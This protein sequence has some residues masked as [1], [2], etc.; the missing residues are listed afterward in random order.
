[1][2]DWY[3]PKEF[4]IPSNIPVI[5]RGTFSLREPDNN[6]YFYFDCIEW[7]PEDP[8]YEPKPKGEEDD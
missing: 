6:P 1:M 4:P 3:C 5:V 8:F 7:Q 2:S